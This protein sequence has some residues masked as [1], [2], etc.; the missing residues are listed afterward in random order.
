MTV[1]SIE[2]RPSPPAAPDRAAP[3][4][5]PCALAHARL[6]EAFP[7]LRVHHGPPRSGGGWV[8]GARLLH[9]PAGLRELIDFDVRDGLDRYGTVLRPDVAAG[10]CLHRYCWPVGLLFTLPW[11][12]ERRV[13]VLP[14]EAL[15]LRRDT[16]E[17]TAEPGAFFCLPQDPAAALPGALVVADEAALRERLLAALTEH[18]T[19]VLA[20][21][22]PEVRRGPRTLWACATDAVVEGLWQVSAAL[23][24]EERAVD[25]LRSLLP[26]H[27]GART[28]PFLAGTGFRF[29]ERDGSSPVRTRTRAGCCLLYTVRPA[30]SCT[31]CPRVARC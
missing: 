28:A 17:L 12:L 4:A 25:A 30:D 27:A 13:P 21:F 19:P 9:D 20:V 22:R 10:F 16:G 24:E 18:F 7:T 14:P 29:E 26:E 2:P 5:A 15:S 8:S 1:S 6:G 23:G 11:L 3:A 31:G